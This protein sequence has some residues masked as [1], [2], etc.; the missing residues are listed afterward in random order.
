M[1]KNTRHIKK[2]FILFGIVLLAIL[3]TAIVLVSLYYDSYKSRPNDYA[4]VFDAGSS[5]L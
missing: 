2:I 3:I 4:I 1:L 5:G